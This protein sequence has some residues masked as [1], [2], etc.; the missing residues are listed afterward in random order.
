M[1]QWHLYFI[2]NQ[3]QGEPSIQM[4]VVNFSPGSMQTLQQ[5]KD[6]MEAPARLTAENN[7]FLLREF[8]CS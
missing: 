6:V 8:L 5:H 7:T 2:E 4:K 3:S 1:S